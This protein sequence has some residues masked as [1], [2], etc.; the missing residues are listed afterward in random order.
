MGE[1][2]DAL[3][4]L[5]L[6][7]VAPGLVLVQP[8]VQHRLVH[9]VALPALDLRKQ[10]QS[11]RIKKLMLGQRLYQSARARAS[12]HRGHGY[13]SYRVMGFFLDSI[14]SAVLPY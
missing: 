11:R 7:Q 13:E 8:G 4:G 5:E 9:R 12:C 6:P 2:P 14:L 10:D 3:L 1:P